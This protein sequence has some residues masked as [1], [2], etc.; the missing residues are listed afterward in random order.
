MYVKL[1]SWRPPTVIWCSHNS[2]C[3]MHLLAYR[4]FHYC[5]EMELPACGLW[6]LLAW[7]DRK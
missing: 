7:P 2:I 5:M 1:D 4:L 6:P 3:I